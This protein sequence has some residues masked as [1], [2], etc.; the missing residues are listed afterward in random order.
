MTRKA[1]CSF[2]TYFVVVVENGT[3]EGTQFIYSTVVFF[4]SVLSSLLECHFKIYG[5]QYA[6]P[7]TKNN[8]YYGRLQNCTRGKTDIH[9]FF[10]SATACP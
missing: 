3:Q 10:A 1:L 5:C 8:S 6:F 7:T 2:K 4:P 9:I